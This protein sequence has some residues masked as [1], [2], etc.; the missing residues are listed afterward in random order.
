MAA[1]RLAELRAVPRELRIEALERVRNDPNRTFD[2]YV[3]TG[4]G[5]AYNEQGEAQLILHGGISDLA[6]VAA[7]NH[8]RSIQN[9]R[10]LAQID[11][12]RAELIRR[13]W[14]WWREPAARNQQR[15][16]RVQV[17][18]HPLVDGEDPAPEVLRAYIIDQTHE[19]TDDYTLRRFREEQFREVGLSQP[20]R[21][22]E[23]FERDEPFLWG[24]PIQVLERMVA[25]DVD[26]VT[27]CVIACARLVTEAASGYTRPLTQAVR[28]Q[29]EAF[30]AAAEGAEAELDEV[31]PLPMT[32][33]VRREA[34]R[35][36]IPERYRRASTPVAPTA[37]AVEAQAAEEADPPNSLGFFWGSESEPASEEVL[38]ARREA[39][40]RAASGQVH[41]EQG[42]DAVADPDAEWRARV[43]TRGDAHCAHQPF[44]GGI[45]AAM[46]ATELPGPLLQSFRSASSWMRISSAL[47][48][49][50]AAGAGDWRFRGR[51]CVRR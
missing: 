23:R 17:D 49:R 46:R 47:R 43:Q 48:G 22:R 5:T 36:H 6:V 45:L 8:V 1:A 39:Y 33:E 31:Q 12:K 32:L 29:A 41:A 25:G 15:M 27:R 4:E 40:G 16:T 26:Q 50:G 2:Y 14:A 44:V 9:E 10:F 19:L 21:E 7:L 37:A 35:R 3:P 28:D 24:L 51:Y 30:L 18:R 11:E 34:Y 20:P 38:A 13:F 42:A